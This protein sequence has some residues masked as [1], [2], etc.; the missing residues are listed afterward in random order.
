M[1]GIKPVSPDPMLT[2]LVLIG[3][4]NDAKKPKKRKSKP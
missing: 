4:A 2:A 3:L 1:K